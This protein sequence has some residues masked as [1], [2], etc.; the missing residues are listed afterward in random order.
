MGT[1]KERGI[2]T[3]N[4][5]SDEVLTT[6]PRNDK[7]TTKYSVLQKTKEK[8]SRIVF[9][10]PLLHVMNTSQFEQSSGDTVVNNRLLLLQY[11]LECEKLLEPR[12]GLALITSKG[13]GPYTQWRLHD[14]LVPYCSKMGFLGHVPFSVKDYPGYNC[15]NVE[16]DSHVKDTEGR[17]YVFG[18]SFEGSL[19]KQLGINVLS[20]DD[21]REGKSE[22]WPE[23]WKNNDESLVLKNNEGAI[24]SVTHCSSTSE[25][26]ITFLRQFAD[27]C[28]YKNFCNICCAGPFTGKADEQQH[29]A[30][31]THHRFLRNEPL[32]DKAVATLLENNQFSNASI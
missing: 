20:K 10:F 26:V 24:V 27:R 1:L 6:S 5:N 15:Q 29:L 19:W 18:F 9:Q 13:V 11:L 4:E 28:N 16:R 8:F 12:E 2:F 25:V 31:K 21:I 17:T 14:K 30:S 3:Q 23:R 22:L 7:N 32:W